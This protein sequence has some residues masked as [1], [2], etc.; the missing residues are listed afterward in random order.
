M[1]PRGNFDFLP[2]QVNFLPGYVF[3]N[4]NM[5]KLS[6]I[7]LDNKTETIEFIARLSELVKCTLGGFDSV[8]KDVSK[9]ISTKNFAYRF[10]YFLPHEYTNLDNLHY[11]KIFIGEG[12]EI[13]IKIYGR[14]LEI[15]LAIE[16]FRMPPTSEPVDG[17]DKI[18]NLL[19]QTDVELDSLISKVVV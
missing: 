13:L 1:P 9:F 2:R 12:S 6:K 16:E 5:N 3:Y 14:L 7:N 15:F 19:K 4:I 18:E 8:Y 10:S 11:E 17:Y